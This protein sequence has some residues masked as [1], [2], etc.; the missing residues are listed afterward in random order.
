LKRNFLSFLGFLDFSLIV[1]GVYDNFDPQSLGESPKDFGLPD[2]PWKSLPID[3]ETCQK[4]D[5]VKEDY[6]RKIM[7]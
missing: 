5:Q 7:K 2:M 1:V 3:P 4:I 6:T